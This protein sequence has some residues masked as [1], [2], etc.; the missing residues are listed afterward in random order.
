MSNWFEPLLKWVP[1]GGVPIAFERAPYIV[2]ELTQHV[3]APIVAVV[4]AAA[5]AAIIVRHF[6]QTVGAAFRL[7]LMTF[8]ATFGV[9]GA[10]SAVVAL[11]LQYS[12]VAQHIAG[13]VHPSPA[14]PPPDESPWGWS[15]GLG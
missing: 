1:A 9:L 13:I 11:W 15:W 14:G 12:G 4:L 6:L 5:L 8:V 3:S 7:L 2:T 10:V